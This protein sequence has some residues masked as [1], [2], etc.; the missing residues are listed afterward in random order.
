MIFVLLYNNFLKLELEKRK[1]MGWE[2]ERDDE[3]LGMGYEAG[4][5]PEGETDKIVSWEPFRDWL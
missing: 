3:R 5:D 2:L 1:A 4:S